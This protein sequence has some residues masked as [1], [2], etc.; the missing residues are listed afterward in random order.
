M[1]AA[2]LVVAD[3]L[4]VGALGEAAVHGARGAHEDGHDVLARGGER[5]LE[6][7][8]QFLA[9]LAVA[10]V[11][12]QELEDGVVP[13]VAHRLVGEVLHLALERAGK[14]AQAARGVE[15]LEVDAVDLH[16]LQ[17]FQGRHL[18][19]L[20]VDHRLAGLDVFV[21]EAVGGPGQIV[22]ERVGGELRE[23]ADAHL[24]FLEVRHSLDD[25]GCRDGDEARCQAALRDEGGLGALG[26]LHDLLGDG[27]VLG[28]VQVVDALGLGSLGDHRVAEERRAAHHGP[29]AVERLVDGD[30]VVEATR[31]ALRAGRQRER[32]LDVRVVRVHDKHLVVA[33]SLEEAGDHAADLSG[34]EDEDVLHGCVCVGWG[35]WVQ[36]GMRSMVWPTSCISSPMVSGPKWNVRPAEVKSSGSGRLAPSARPFL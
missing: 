19:H 35:A 28:E 31:H 1:V 18:G 33:A 15:R 5:A 27:H 7:G 16:V 25:V 23:R 3:D 22:L 4:G 6:R 13:G 29:L 26:E 17:P 10:Q 11:P 21:D 36:A 24:H 32:L 9:V 30:L 2:D 34:T 12:E 14:G 8:L 20:A